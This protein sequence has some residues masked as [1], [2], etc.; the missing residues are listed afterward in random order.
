M[1]NYK[2]VTIS[3]AGYEEYTLNL[4]KSLKKFGEASKLHV[5]CLDEKSFNSLNQSGLNT[6]FIDS[7]I[8]SNNLKEYGT[9]DFNKFMYFKMKI[10]HELLKEEEFVFYVDSDVVFKNN[11]NYFDKDLKNFEILSMKDFNFKTPK[12]H[13]ICAGFMIV[14]SNIKT[15]KIF[16]PKKILKNKFKYDDQHLINSRRKFINNKYLET[17][18]FCNGSFFLNNLK[19]LDPIAVHFNFIK[20]DKKKEIMKKHGYWLID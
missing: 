7:K 20:G 8:F 16:N 18:L 13:Y 14:K 19:K 1:I 5:Y 4:A 17:D 15:R 3:S 2:L 9:T 12:K 11:L 10:I 6:K